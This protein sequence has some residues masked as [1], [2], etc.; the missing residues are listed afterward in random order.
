MRRSLCVWFPQWA[1]Q[2]RHH[3]QPRL[4]GRPLVLY[5]DRG[6][7]GLRVV[8]CCHEAAQKGVQPGWP[9]AEA[10]SMLSVN[11]NPRDRRRTPAYLKA[12]PIADRSGLQELALAAQ[13][14]TP[15]VGIE[16]GPDPESLLLDITGC[17]QLWQDER[18]LLSAVL[19]WIRGQQY[20]A[21]VAIA[22]TIGGAWAVAHF[23]ASPAI[24]LSGHL[25]AALN[26]LP[27][28]ALRLPPPVVK[29][30]E[31]FGVHTIADLGKLPRDSLPSRF[32]KD[33][34][35][36]WDQTW[37]T[38][39]ETFT[40]ER[41]QEPIRESW[42]SDDALADS[43]ALAYVHRQLMDRVLLNLERHRAGLREWSCHLAGEHATVWDFRLSQPTTDRKH[44][45]QLVRLR[46]ERESL[47]PDINRLD[48]EVRQIGPLSEQQESLFDEPQVEAGRAVR[49]LVDCLKS[50]LGEAAVLTPVYVPDPLPEQSCRLVPWSGESDGEETAGPDPLVASSRPLR[51]HPQPHPL[52]VMSVIPDGPPMQLFLGNRPCRVHRHWGPERVRSAW[53][54]RRDVKRD[55]Y[56]V[57]TDEGR[58]LWIYRDGD[59]GAWFLHGDFA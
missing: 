42:S 35:R 39:A 2:R 20:Q 17:A 5:D 23:G 43:A 46:C 27:V 33:L 14:F 41:F 31:G 24:I 48:L 26:P 44:L 59:T 38:I 32:G 36:R 57:E 54:R 52:R 51:L 56:R 40:P 8:D 18:G 1:I 25:A 21:R 9:M 45:D 11:N 29:S 19:R 4:R 6:S 53:W 10:R 50:R 34:L 37:G 49:R 16:E 22:D 13:E 28:P 30:L 3:E 47:S 12:D 15:L 7:R 55:Y 58:H